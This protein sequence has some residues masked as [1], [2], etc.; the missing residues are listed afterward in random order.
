MSHILFG[1]GAKG[2]LVE[3]LQVGLVTHGVPLEKIDGDFGTKTRDA[4]RAFQLR[5]GTDPTG[6]I[7][8]DEWTSITGKPVPTLFERSLQLTASFEGHNYTLAVGNFDGAWLTW[9]IIGFT[10]KHGE[11]QRIVLE[12][13]NDLPHLITDA[14]AAD[15]AELIRIMKAPAV[16]QRAW[17]NSVTVSGHRL[18]EPWRSAFARL[19]QFG[20]VQAIQNRRAHDNYFMP[21]TRVASTLGIVSECGLALCFDIHV[22]NGG[23]KPEI[24]QS[25]TPLTPGEPEQPL[26]ERIARE[27][28]Q[29]AKPEFRNDVLVRK[30]TVATGSGI[31]HGK[32]YTLAN[33]G[34]L[35]I[36]VAIA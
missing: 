15:G 10:L 24:R 35:P 32:H 29:S 9:G 22:Q 6:A 8:R 31:V 20:D 33:W 30:M 23:I 13:E 34:I 11:V 7:T 2:R 16:E 17:A 19:G 3:D 27:V 4:V 5:E 36:A 14:F 28:A 21:A 12:I 18:A 26:L 1:V 25:L